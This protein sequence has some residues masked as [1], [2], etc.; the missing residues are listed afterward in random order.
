MFSDNNGMWLKIS[1][2]NDSESYFKN[3]QSEIKQN[4]ST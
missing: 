2:N 1:N 3:E 4:M